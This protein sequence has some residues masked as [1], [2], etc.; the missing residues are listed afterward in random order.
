MFAC[1][2]DA[3]AP[4]HGFAQS[5]GPL[6]KRRELFDCGG[7]WVEMLAD[8]SWRSTDTKHLME[9]INMTFTQH[10]LLILS[11]IPLL[12][13]Y[14]TVRKDGALLRCDSTVYVCIVLKQLDEM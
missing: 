6:S 4:N 14:R 5:V 7:S 8:E 2:S 1:I 9:C 11:V 3:R 12:P 10:I 13:S